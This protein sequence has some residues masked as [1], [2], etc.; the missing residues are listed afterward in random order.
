VNEF[1]RF[2][3]S[4]EGQQAVQAEGDYIPLSA[5]VAK[6]ERARLE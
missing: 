4:K 6:Q 2:V 3:L 5:E 1:L